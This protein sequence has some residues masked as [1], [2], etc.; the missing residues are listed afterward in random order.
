M[1]AL[2]MHQ[3]RR[4]LAQLEGDAPSKQKR[5]RKAHHRRANE[6]ELEFVD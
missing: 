6:P 4:C 3:C 2:V 1:P 5:G